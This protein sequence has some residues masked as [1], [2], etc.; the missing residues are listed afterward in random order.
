MILA[1]NTVVQKSAGPLYLSLPT[2]F[3]GQFRMKVAPNFK[4]K[5]PNIHL[6]LKKFEG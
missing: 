3:L 1:A 4:N 6:L 2:S 5:P